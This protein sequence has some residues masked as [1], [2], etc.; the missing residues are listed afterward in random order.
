M[1]EV[2]FW[3]LSGSKQGVPVVATQEG[4]TMLSGF[5]AALMKDILVDGDVD[6]LAL[7]ARVVSSHPFDDLRLPASPADAEETVRMCLALEGHDAH[8]PEEPCVDH[9]F[10]FDEG[11]EVVPAVPEVE[12]DAV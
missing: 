10:E 9:I 8:H 7:V 11:W 2:V 4:V 1:P 5:S 6:P 12:L 3:N